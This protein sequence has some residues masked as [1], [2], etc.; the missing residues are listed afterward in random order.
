MGKV[1]IVGSG[2]AG[3]WAA[4]GAARRID[5][6]GL[7]PDSVEITVLSRT[8]HH[9]IRVRN[10]ERDLGGCRLPL[11][12]LLAPAGVSHLLGTATTIDADDHTVIAQTSDG[13]IAVEYDRLV[14]AA[15]SQVVLP[16]IPGLRDFAFDVDTYDGATRL[17]EHLDSLDP[18]IPGAGTVAVVGAGLTGI[19]TACELPARLTAHFGQAPAPRVLLTDH[20]RAVGSDM[21]A[22]ARPVIEEALTR[23][24]VEAITG[25]GVSAVPPTR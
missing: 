24:G 2:F 22:S 16:D 21:G 18:D 19:E 15:G 7:P 17:G 13:T 3:L 12:G 8:A 23:C 25:T 4:L 11:D 1:L 6:L 5:E 9:D 20:N 14:L 10:Y